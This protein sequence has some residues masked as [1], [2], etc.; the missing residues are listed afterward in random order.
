MSL[1]VN[2]T[3]EFGEYI[4]QQNAGYHGYLFQD[5]NDYMANTD[6]P[7]AVVDSGNFVGWATFHVIEADGGGSKSVR[8]CF[9][10]ASTNSRPTI[11]RRALRTTARATSA[12]TF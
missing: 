4:G 7:V 5:V 3:L 8:G 1:E 11:S 2:K 6:W 9:T 10:T 12:P